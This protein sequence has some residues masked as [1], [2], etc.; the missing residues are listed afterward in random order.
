[1]HSIIP[2]VII[3]KRSGLLLSSIS[4]SPDRQLLQ[5]S[6]ISPVDILVENDDTNPK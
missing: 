3:G 6:Y 4:V 1:M 2:F 5:S